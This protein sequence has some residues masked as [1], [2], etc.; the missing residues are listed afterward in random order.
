MDGAERRLHEVPYSLAKADGFESGIIDSLYLR[1]GV[2]SIVEFKT[3]RARDE[4]ELQRLLTEEGYLAQAE[5][6]VAAAERLLGGRPR[7][8]FCMLNCAGTVRLI[9]PEVGPGRA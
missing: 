6:Y 4:V 1:A 7:F 9:T 3:D 8:I 2:W 5:R